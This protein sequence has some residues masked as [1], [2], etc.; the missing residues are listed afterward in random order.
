MF[1]EILVYIQISNVHFFSILQC[2][3]YVF[4]FSYIQVFQMFIASIYRS[5]SNILV[6]MR[7]NEHF[8]YI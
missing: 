5:I 4:C 2:I 6:H 3:S 1:I 7:N 8:L